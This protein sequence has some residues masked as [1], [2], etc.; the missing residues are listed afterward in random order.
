MQYLIDFIN[1]ATEAEITQYFTDNGCTVVKEWDNFDK[2]FLVETN[3]V[4]AKTSLVERLVE[5]NSVSIVPHDVI[6]VD[7]RF[8][9]HPHDDYPS[10]T[11]N[12]NDQKDWWKNFS[13][14]QPKFETDPLILNRLGQS[15][16]VYLMDSGI[17]D[18]HPEFVGRNVTKL[19]SV[20]PN[21]F[22]DRAGHGTALGSLIVGNTC[23]ITDAKLKV[24][25]IFDPNHATLQSEFLDALDA[26]I[27][28]HVDNT[29]AILNASWSIPKNE[30]VEHK[31]SLAVEEGIF[32]IAAAGNT[33][34]SIE[35]VTP[36][37]MMEVITMGAY[38]TELQPCDFSNYTGPASTGTG[39]VNHGALDGWAP[40]EQ[41]WA[42][43][44]NGGYC[45]ISGTSAAAAITSAIT[46]CNLE[47][48][49]DEEGNK[50]W[51]YN[52]L[53]LNSFSNEWTADKPNQNHGN[54]LIFAR[55]DMLEYT[56]PKYNNSINRLATIHDYCL[57]IKPQPADEVSMIA[58]VGHEYKPLIYSSAVT[59]AIEPLDPMPP[60]FHLGAMGRVIVR[61][62][63]ENAPAEGEHYRLYS[64][65]FNR[66][67]MDDSSELFTLNIYVMNEDKDV[68][69]IP[70]NDPVIP[71]T[72]LALCGGLGCVP[73][74]TLSCVDTCGLGCCAAYKSIDIACKCDPG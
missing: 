34:V 26:I 51:Y 43:D 22:T 33:G 12:T 44:L 36:A 28:D 19:Y 35:D 66:I 20:I 39:I 18:T 56:D 23:G 7:Q 31:L 11:V 16:T 27:N 29:F 69:E 71:I 9:C 67:G 50:E 73:G 14:Q 40:G 55:Y 49:T 74:S 58:K 25:K 63:A 37:S 4:P 5:E 45:Y 64:L 1:T 38:N 70:E 62:T 17:E 30:W 3:S 61:P 53:I 57:K 6:T 59:K 2:V 13:Y 52:Q 65:R 8:H 41:I 46:A 68:S 10:I 15:I 32:V 48:H 60:N 24:I 54:M 47:W 72:L 42:A 21:D